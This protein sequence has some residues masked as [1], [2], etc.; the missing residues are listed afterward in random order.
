MSIIEA[1]AETQQQSARSL[2]RTVM[3]WHRKTVWMK[4]EVYGS[5]FPMSATPFYL[6]AALTLDLQMPSHILSIYQRSDPSRKFIAKEV[7]EESNELDIFKLL[8]TFQ[9]KS[10]HIIALHESFQTRSKSWAILPEMSSVANIVSLAPKQLYGKSLQSA[11][12]SSR[13][14]TS[15]PKTL[16]ST[17]TFA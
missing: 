4:A 13:A 10:E 9:P 5:C 11:G 15:T 3:S 12:A 14:W 2:K 8:D 7:S 1:R 16:L 17:G 6:Y